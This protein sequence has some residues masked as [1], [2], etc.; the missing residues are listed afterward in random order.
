MADDLEE[1]IVQ[2]TFFDAL[3]ELGF[4]GAVLAIECY[5]NQ[6]CS[7]LDTINLREKSRTGGLAL[8]DILVTVV[9][10]NG[11]CDRKGRVWRGLIRPCILS[12]CSIIS[13]STSY[14]RLVHSIISRMFCTNSDANLCPR[15]HPRFCSRP[16]SDTKGGV[17]ITCSKMGYDTISR[18]SISR[19]ESELVLKSALYRYPKLWLFITMDYPN[20]PLMCGNNAT[21][22]VC[23]IPRS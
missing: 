2:A 10:D 17:H 15:Y 9:D 11:D 18:I 23:R 8:A 22:P 14:L 19:L 12:V 3:N 4:G 7:S 6:P 13:S 5:H 20:P 21:A 1:P 16:P